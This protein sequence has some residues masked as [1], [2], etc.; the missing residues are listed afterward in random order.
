MKCF[1]A[2]I[3]RLFV[4]TF[5]VTILNAAMNLQKILQAAVLQKLWSRSQGIFV[6]AGVL[7]E[8]QEKLELEP[9]NFDPTLPSTYC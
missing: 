4:S 9:N 5:K 2:Y 8:F 6:L 7:L 1:V 3:V